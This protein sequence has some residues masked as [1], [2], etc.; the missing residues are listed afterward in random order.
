MVPTDVTTVQS[1]RRRC[2]AAI[3]ARAA[4]ARCA[5][6]RFCAAVGWADDLVRREL[7]TLNKSPTGTD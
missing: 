1:R 4:S 2:D 5:E 7:S 6:S 3:R